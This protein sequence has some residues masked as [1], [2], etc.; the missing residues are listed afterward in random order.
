MHY[1]LHP[2]AV[3]IPSMT[4]FQH[5]AF[6]VSIQFILIVFDKNL[7]R[8]AIVH[9]LVLQWSVSILWN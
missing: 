4:H 7:K 3:A 8:E 1:E 9:H 6:F 2:F 5:A